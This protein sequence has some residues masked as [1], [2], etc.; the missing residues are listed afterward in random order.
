MEKYVLEVREE[1][2]HGYRGIVVV[3]VKSCNFYE[4]D[5]MVSGDGY[6]I[7]HDIV[8]HVNGLGEI[9]TVC[10]EFQALGA[11]WYTR[12]QFADLRRDRV[13]AAY[14]P[15]ESIASDLARMARYAYHDGFHGMLGP[16]PETTYDEVF[17]L[18][19]ELSMRRID[20]E[21][22][23]GAKPGDPEDYA[24]FVKEYKD[25]ALQGMRRGITLQH[26][27]F[28]SPYVAHSKFYTIVDAVSHIFRDV[29]DMPEG[30][31]YELVIKDRGE[32]YVLGYGDD[33][34]E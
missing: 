17:G 9:G 13:G 34:E 25:Q 31:Q 16:Q 33:E 8:E 14:T 30:Y 20:E 4:G 1:P 11:L 27:R 15:E 10:D 6:G 18:I 5:L 22:W 3:G 28:G 23:G 26:E 7:A 32:A 12:G 2:D 19:I 29:E 21:V 24:E